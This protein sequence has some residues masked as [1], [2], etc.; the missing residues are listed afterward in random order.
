MG[1]VRE[2]PWDTGRVWV[3]ADGSGKGSQ[4]RR[5]PWGAEDRPAEP[6][7]G[8]GV[9]RGG[10]S[11]NRGRLIC[12]EKKGRKAAWSA[13]PRR[14]DRTFQAVAG[15]QRMLSA[16]LTLTWEKGTEL[17]GRGGVGSEHGKGCRRPFADG[18]PRPW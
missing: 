6:G 16:A 14:L 2:V 10:V 18:F 1:T 11:M 4:I 17:W 9:E 13:C 12:W 5:A 8:G 15:K 7:G 3:G